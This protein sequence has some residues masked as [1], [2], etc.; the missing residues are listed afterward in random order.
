M[1][2]SFGYVPPVSVIPSE[3]AAATESKDPYIARAFERFDNAVSQVLAVSKRG[4]AQVR[5]RRK[6]K[7]GSARGGEK[8]V[9]TRVTYDMG[10]SRQ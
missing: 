8:A 9:K 3:V 4:I 1:R 7:R 10:I 6:R 2:N 5:G